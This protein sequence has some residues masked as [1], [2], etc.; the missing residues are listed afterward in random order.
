MI[1]YYVS[2]ICQLFG[3]PTRK[4]GDNRDQS[5]VCNGLWE[6]ECFIE[7]LKLK[8]LCFSAP[9]HQYKYNNK[10]KKWWCHSDLAWKGWWAWAVVQHAG[11]SLYWMS[12]YAWSAS[13]GENLRD[14]PILS[15]TTFSS[16]TLRSETRTP[17]PPTPTWLAFLINW[18]SMLGFFTLSVLTPYMHRG[19]NWPQQTH[20][21]SQHR[22][23]DVEG[24]PQK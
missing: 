4:L 21:T 7:P 6:S 1:V 15:W 14:C 2:F 23:E 20:K 13:H 3:C 17:H 16:L 11:M 10:K 9:N 22:L 24:H 19:W 12:L 18:L 8:L 5:V